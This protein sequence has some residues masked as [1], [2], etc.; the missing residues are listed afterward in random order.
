MDGYGKLYFSNGKL[1]YQGHWIEDK[2]HG[3]GRIYE[4][5]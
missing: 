1:A 3:T 2:F 4:N 5:I